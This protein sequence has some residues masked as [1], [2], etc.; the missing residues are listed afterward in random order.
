MQND[1]AQDFDLIRHAA[2]EAGKLALSYWGR[3][4]EKQ[5]KADGS[6]VTEA[7][8]A[9]DALLAEQLKR[10]RPAYGWLSEESAEHI[11]RLRARR[12]WVVDPIDGTRAFIQG[13][14]DWVVALALIE[15]HV[16]VLAAVVNPVRGETFEARAGAGTFLNGRKIHASKQSSL[17]GARLTITDSLLKPSRWRRPWPPVTSVV[18]NSIIYRLALVASGTADATFAPKPKWEWDIAAGALLVSEAGG[19]VTDPC[20][21]PLKF[22]SSEAKVPGYVAAAP[23][24][25]HILV[26]RMSDALDGAPAARDQPTFDRNGSKVES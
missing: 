19:I 21:F 3:S 22:N 23:K 1:Y 12:V 5:R 18:A 14:D 10:A 26:E 16:P 7:D 9:V 8:Y 20:G 15:D 2:Q 24:L 17:S 6:E 11:E 13:R 25:H 4:I